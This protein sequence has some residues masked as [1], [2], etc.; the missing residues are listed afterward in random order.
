MADWYA[1]NPFPLKTKAGFWWQNYTQ[2]GSP[3]PK[4]TVHRGPGVINTLAG[5]RQT[6][7][8]D[9]VNVLALN[10]LDLTRVPDVVYRFPN[11]EEIDLS[12]N[13]LTQ[14]PARLTA[15]LPRLRRLSV[16][17]NAIPDDSVFFSKNRHLTA[18]NLQGNRLTRVPASVGLN[19]GLES[20]WLGNNTL[21]Q[22]NT[23]PLHRLRRLND[24]NLYSAG[25]N[26]LPTSIK[27]L[28]H[29]TV[30]DLYYNKLTTLPKQLTKLRRLEQL[31]LSH[32]DLSA[33]PPTLARLRHLQQLYAHHNSQLPAGFSRLRTLTVLNLG[34]NWITVVPPSLADLPALSELDLN[35][36]NIQEFPA[37]LNSIKTLKRVYLGSNPLFGSEAMNSRYAPQ[38]QQLQARQTEVFY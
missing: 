37:V 13:Q 10:Q 20:L 22:L 5:A 34:Y 14:L 28:H 25:L 27:R 9:T 21:A 12:R 24:L 29:L 31:A 8:P 1:A 6:D 15:D 33:L 35:N 38:I 26:R 36:N 18:L 7:R 2:I 16:L 17:Y 30:L 11:L 19:R 3:K 23:K 32:N 4:R